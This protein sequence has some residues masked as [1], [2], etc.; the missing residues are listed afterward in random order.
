MAK[1]KIKSNPY[2]KTTE[3]KS[4]D[5]MVN[6]WKNIDLHT[7]P[8]SPLLRSDLVVGFFPFKAKEIIERLGFKV[9]FSNI[10]L[11]N[12]LFFVGFYGNIFETRR[13]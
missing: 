3:F 7:S 2:Q 13:C 11:Q 4:W 1:I 12:L 6:D 9:K 10:N 5:E 8:N